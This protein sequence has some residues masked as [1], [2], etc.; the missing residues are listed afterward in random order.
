MYKNT[1]KLQSSIL[2]TSRIDS[3]FEI[4]IHFLKF[5]PLNYA[6]V[7]A[8]INKRQSMVMLWFCRILICSNTW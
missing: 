6:I 4:M 8:F 2:L 1:L 3:I 5:S 7:Q